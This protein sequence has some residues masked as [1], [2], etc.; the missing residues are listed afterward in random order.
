MQ[1]SCWSRI[2]T[3]GCVGKAVIPRRLGVMPRMVPQ[4]PSSRATHFI[5]GHFA[6]STHALAVHGYRTLRQSPSRVE[7]RGGATIH[8]RAVL[9]SICSNVYPVF[10][11]SLKAGLHTL[12]LAPM[13]PTRPTK[14]HIL[15]T[16]LRPGGCSE[17]SVHNAVLA[18]RYSLKG[19]R[20]IIPRL[21]TMTCGLCYLG[22][23]G[24]HAQRDAPC[25]STSPCC[26]HH[27]VL[28][29]GPGGPS[30]A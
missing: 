28:R 16:C 6:F 25:A 14:A 12:V 7:R 26:S 13:P 30:R 8:R 27:C 11:K 10:V 2:P 24:Y 23:Q 22:C 29:V 18:W 20:A 17:S 4:V 5:C 19:K 15:H 9:P 21:R 1:L 3:H